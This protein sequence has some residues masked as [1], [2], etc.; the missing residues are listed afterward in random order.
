MTM[1]TILELWFLVSIPVSL[2]TGHCIAFSMG[3]LQ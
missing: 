2:I 1:L 3:E